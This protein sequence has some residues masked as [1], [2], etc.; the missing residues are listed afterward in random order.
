MV[1]TLLAGATVLVSLSAASAQ[2]LRKDDIKPLSPAECALIEKRTDQEYYITGPVTIGRATIKNSSVL[3]GG[4]V[5]NGVD[6]F[7]VIN[8]SCFSGKPT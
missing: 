2:G 3:K 7:D 8:R 6:N 4:I 5:M 1:R